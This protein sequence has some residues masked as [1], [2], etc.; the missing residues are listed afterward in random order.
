MRIRARG[1]RQG[2]KTTL[3]FFFFFFFSVAGRNLVQHLRAFSSPPPP[4]RPAFRLI[5]LLAGI[6][7]TSLAT[8][9]YT[10]AQR[11][12]HKLIPVPLHPQVR[13]TRALGSRE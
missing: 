7:A 11:Y 8:H 13:Q 4:S 1:R 3:A 5:Q 9:A 12:T 2:K 6:D 10:L